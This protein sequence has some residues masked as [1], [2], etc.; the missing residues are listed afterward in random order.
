M[1]TAKISLAFLLL[2]TSFVSAQTKIISGI[3]SA[4]SGSLD[5]VN[6]INLVNEKSTTSTS[7]GTFSIE[8][9]V[10]DLLVFSSSLFE[11]KRKI[12]TAEDIAAGKISLILIPKPLQIDEVVIESQQLDA[13]QMGILSKPAKRYTPAERRLKTASESEL[14][15]GPMMLMMPTDFII[16]AI[17]GRTKLLK[18]ELA[19]ERRERSLQNLE[20]LFTVEYMTTSLK[21]PAEKVGEFRYFA[22]E[23]DD[24]GRILQEKDRTKATF[25]LTQIAE[26]FKQRQGL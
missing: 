11:Y 9:S 25:L 7:S 1:Q 24:F 23:Q 3:I 10:D 12:I 20:N 16:N 4:E 2:V 13:H 5:G 15:I 6:I 18:K 26:R 17:S 19:I 22:I 8:V 14:T 21:I